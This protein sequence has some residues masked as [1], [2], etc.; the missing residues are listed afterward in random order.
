MGTGRILPTLL[1]LGIP[2]SAAGISQT[3]FEVSDALF[4]SRLGEEQI[5]GVSLVGPVIFLCFAL[6]QAANVGI[7][8][9]L[10]R[11]LGEDRHNDARDVLNHGLA[12]SF[13]IGLTLTAA[14]VI[15]KDPVLH[16]LGGEGNILLY[17]S[18][19]ASIMFYAVVMLHVST[20]GG[21]ALRAQGNT[22]TPMKIGIAANGAN[23]AL[24][25]FF[26]FVLG[27]GVQGAAIGTLISRTGM[28]IASV[29][30]LWSSRSEVRPGRIRGKP[31]F[32]RWSVVG[33]I[34]W[35]GLPASVGMAAMASSMLVLNR[36]IVELDPIAVGV[37]G[38]AQRMQGFAFTPVFGLV[39]AAVPMVGYNL[40]AR[41][42]PRCSAT[43]WTGAVVA[44]V[45]M[46]LVGLVFYAFPS[47][48]F[49]LFIG[50]PDIM[51]MGSDFFRIVVPAYPAIGAS[52]LLGAGFQG[53]G[54]AWIAMIS[55]VLRT[56]AV[57][58]PLA[59]W[60]APKWGVLG[61]WSSF[62]I[63]SVATTIVLI[64]VMQWLLKR[65]RREYEI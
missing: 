13:I 23:I 42:L 2:A 45:F 59:Y 57:R 64:V 65:F 43:I 24:D 37:V 58:V 51:Q 34:Y 48:F 16:S 49:G 15:A 12:S 29:A 35:I 62:P 28:A 38:I 3:L 54:E 10:S 7:A 6:A 4:I 5:S 32:W 8:A 46:T 14:L 47:F 41:N 55:H 25:A 44:A 27:L 33:D 11:R 20:A 21:S 60:L 31:L 40:G 63:S 61:V 56:W 26:I 53:L 30:I 36:L 52:V 39:A 19:Y 1:R 18:R 9:L 50:S 17:A 22:I